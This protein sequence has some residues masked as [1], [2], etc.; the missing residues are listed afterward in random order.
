MGIFVIFLKLLLPTLAN[1]SPHLV[2]PTSRYYQIFSQFARS[3]C[4]IMCTFC[5]RTILYKPGFFGFSLR[6]TGK[7]RENKT[8]RHIPWLEPS[9]SGTLTTLIGLSVMTL[10]D[11]L[12]PAFQS[13]Q[14]ENRSADKRRP[15]GEILMTV[16]FLRPAP[17]PVLDETIVP[18]TLIGS[19]R[20]KTVPVSMD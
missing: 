10:P 18:R 16:R 19:T 9:I 3:I 13:M 7:G 20:Y 5:N 11:S 12:Q 4:Y 1:F 8:P 15:D 14:A 17:L 6:F 2:L